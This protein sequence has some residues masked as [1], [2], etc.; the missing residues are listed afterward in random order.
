MLDGSIGP[1]LDQ[2]SPALFSMEFNDPSSA[3]KSYL[4]RK[5]KGHQ[6]CATS[7]TGRVGQAGAC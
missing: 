4:G 1:W 5:K 7:L 3:D 6:G 2:N